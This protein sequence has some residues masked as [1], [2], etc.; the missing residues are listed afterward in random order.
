LS[1]DPQ[2]NIQVDEER[3]I[4]T[5]DSKVPVYVIPTNEELMIAEETFKLVGGLED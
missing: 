3:C 2:K 1:L 5:L 4:T